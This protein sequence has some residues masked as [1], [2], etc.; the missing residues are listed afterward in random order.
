MQPRGSEVNK[1]Y[2]STGNGGP[3]NVQG[4][5]RRSS[6]NGG[7][8]VNNNGTGN[9]GQELVKSSRVRQW[10]SSRTISDPNDCRDSLMDQIRRGKK[11]RRTNVFNDRSAPRIH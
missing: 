10:I 7:Q 3:R 9:N 5:N 1:Q 8:R 11:L 2:N 4:N 6:N